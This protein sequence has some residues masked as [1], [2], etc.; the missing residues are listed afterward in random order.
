MRPRTGAAIL[1]HMGRRQRA[2]GT[3]HTAQADSP[4]KAGG[5]GDSIDHPAAC[6]PMLLPDPGLGRAGGAVRPTGLLGTCGS[7]L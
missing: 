6:A 7:A 4:L 3:I 2:E 1:R 5:A